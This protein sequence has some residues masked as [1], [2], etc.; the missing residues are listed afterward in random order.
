MSNDV[1]ILTTLARGLADGAEVHLVPGSDWSWTPATRT[2]QFR[3]TAMQEE[4]LPI[5]LALIAHEIGHAS[6]TAYHVP[7]MPEAPAAVPAWMWPDLLN[8]LED[9]RVERWMLGA[10]PGTAPWFDI[11]FAHER[12]LGNLGS[13]SAWSRRWMLANT[14]EWGAAWQP[15]AVAG[16]EVR[17]ALDATRADRRAYAECAPPTH[18]MRRADRQP[19]VLASAQL[20][21][22]HALAVAD[23]FGRLREAQRQLVAQYLDSNSGARRQA[24]KC[25]SK[26]VREA[27]ALLAA[28]EARRQQGARAACAA[29][30]ELADK[31]V[32]IAEG[33]RYTASARSPE[34]NVVEEEVCDKQT[35]EILREEAGRLLDEPAKERLNNALALRRRPDGSGSI[36]HSMCL[37]FLR[38]ELDRVFPHAR[39]SVWQAGHRSG[40]RL[41]LRKAIQ[42]SADP[43]LLNDVWQRR[44][45]PRKPDAAALLLVD[46]SGSM[47]LQGKIQ[48]AVLAC[49]AC[50]QALREL[51]IP[52]AVY[53]FQDQ[54]IAV[55]GFSEPW[56][57]ALAERVDE[58]QKEAHGTRRNGHN[59]PGHNDD[60]PCLAEAA[61]ILA[62]RRE[63]TRALIVISDGLP[64]GAHS[65]EVDLHSAVA[66]LT[67]ERRVTLAAIGIGEGTDHVSDFYP[68]AQGNV[69]V[70]DFPI[71][72]A[73]TLAARMR[74][75]SRVRSPKTSNDSDLDDVRD[76][77][78]RQLHRRRRM[79]MVERLGDGAA[80]WQSLARD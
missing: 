15:L 65:N 40:R 45:A 69:P 4:G 66:Q 10:F 14:L 19:L 60:G 50:A 61:V 26:D 42:A 31:L 32:E 59:R 74:G 57:P 44:S 35:R 58:M 8:A 24:A 3:A 47:T 22:G 48:A 23:V 11:L 76:A 27:S 52:C 68:D 28:A 51:S 62:G 64:N 33:L 43:H 41:D 37:A 56:S 67:L 54:L 16:D 5:C 38:A 75:G 53:G 80:L 25:E 13:V 46:L 72:L 7:E 73:R 79:Q 30:L 71:V 21:L 1:R 78:R 12:G 63:S 36:S 18:A 2:L 39:P 55:A 9:P 29:S 70:S 49:K 34:A 77:M 6:I 20:A 17:A